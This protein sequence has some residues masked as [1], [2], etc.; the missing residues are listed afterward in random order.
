MI[1]P[2]M[3]KLRI[4]ISFA[5][6]AVLLAGAAIS[7]Y[8]FWSADQLRQRI[9]LWTEQQRER[10]YEISYRGP[11]ITGFPLKLEAN[12]TEPVIASPRGWRWRGPAVSGSAALWDPFTIAIGL[13][14]DHS[15]ERSKPKDR[16]DATIEQALGVVHLGSNGQIEHGT[17]ETG[18][19]ILKSQRNRFSAGRSTWR[20]GPLSPGSGD[21][22]QQLIFAG[23]IEE[24][25]LPEKKAGPLGP[26]V[27]HLAVDGILAGPIPDGNQQQMLKRWRDAGGVLELGRVELDWGPLGLDGKGTLSLDQKFRPLGTFTARLRGMMQTLDRLIAAGL[28]KPGQAVPAKIALLAMG[29]KKDENGEKVIVLPITLQDGQLYLGPAPL[30]KISPVL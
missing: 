3:P 19:V 29:G 16:V 20:L 11:A 9:A 6:V 27:A 22:P 28:L 26:S 30:M 14:G 15:L 4:L 18:P 25:V 7:A 8:W 10:G 12:F 24:L 5:L 2:P 17:A 13:S 23:E 1:R 21:R